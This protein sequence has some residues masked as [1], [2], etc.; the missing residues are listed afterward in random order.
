M[1][2]YQEMPVA[3]AEERAEL[4]GDL[5]FLGRMVVYTVAAVFVCGVAALAVLG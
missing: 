2:T 3:K 1:R 4:I 5:M